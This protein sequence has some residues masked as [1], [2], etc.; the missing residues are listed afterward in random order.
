MPGQLVLHL[1]TDYFLLLF[2]RQQESATLLLLCLLGYKCKFTAQIKSFDPFRT[3]IAK[4]LLRNYG[5]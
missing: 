1:L 3:V 5:R 2:Y 4:V